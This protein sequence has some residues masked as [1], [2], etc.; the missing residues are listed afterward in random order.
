MRVAIAS[1]ADDGRG[2]QTRRNVKGGEDPDDVVFAT[3]KRAD[4][5]CLKLGDLELRDR[6]VVELL[7]VCGGSLERWRIC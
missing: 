2:P 4:L 7:T 1:S 5:V 6:R 3:G